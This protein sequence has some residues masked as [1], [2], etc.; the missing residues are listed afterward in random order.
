MKIEIEVAEEQESRLRE[1]AREQSL[2]LEEIVRICVDK[3]L[4]QP[5]RDRRQLYARAATLV[6][7]F[8]DPQGATDLSAEH[9]R[10]LFD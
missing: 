7:A 8:A 6:G 2:P 10:Y 9:D 4:T 3:A 5:A 1:L